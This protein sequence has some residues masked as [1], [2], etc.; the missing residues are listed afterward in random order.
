MCGDELI[1]CSEH[2]LT[3][4]EETANVQYV[5]EKLKTE[6]FSNQSVRLLNSKNLLIPDVEGTK[7]KLKN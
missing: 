3:L 5:S 4:T 7:G 1:Q 2:P 6:A